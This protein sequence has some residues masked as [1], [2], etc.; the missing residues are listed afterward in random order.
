[1]TAIQFQ[2]Q[3]C[4]PIVFAMIVCM[5]R[6]FTNHSLTVTTYSATNDSQAIKDV[7]RI[8]AD[9]FTIWSHRSTVVK[10]CNKWVPLFELHHYGYA[11]I[12]IYCWTTVS[13]VRKGQYIMFKHKCLIH[14]TK[15]HYRL[16]FFKPNV[17]IEIIHFSYCF[18][19]L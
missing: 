17:T 18:F 6:N 4:S 3:I 8:N 19:F 5:I 1:M 15:H 11:L 16:P 12:W 14:S 7:D 9:D 13:Q 10:T 2:L